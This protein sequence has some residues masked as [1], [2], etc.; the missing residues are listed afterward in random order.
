MALTVA[1]GQ[2]K[3]SPKA[4]ITLLGE[5]VTSQ[6]NNLAVDTDPQAKKLIEW[7]VKGGRG[8]IQTPGGRLF[9]CN[10][11]AFPM[12]AQSP[13]ALCSLIAA[14]EANPFSPI[15]SGRRAYR[16]HWLSLALA[17]TNILLQSKR[18]SK[19]VLMCVSFLMWIAYHMGD[20]QTMRV[21][22]SGYA[23]LIV[24]HWDLF[25]STPYF[26]N[27]PFFWTFP[28]N[29][30]SILP[31]TRNPP[32]GKLPTTKMEEHIS[33]NTLMSL[34]LA[35]FISS[36][37][38]LFLP[39]LLAMQS[40][41]PEKTGQLSTPM[42]KDLLTY[43]LY[44]GRTL[45]SLEDVALSNLETC[46]QH[47]CII[48]YY[49]CVWRNPEAGVGWLVGSMQSDIVKAGLT[50]LIDEY[51]EVLLWFTLLAGHFA[52]S[53][54]RDWWI[55]ILVSVRHAAHLDSYEEARRTMEGR[56]LWTRWLDEAARGFWN[57]TSAIIKDLKMP[58]E[59]SSTP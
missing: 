36:D 52:R 40:M 2:I 1:T 26:R 56:L 7:F 53:L 6:F 49:A 50:R 23:A 39:H 47:A 18:P 12:I 29:E 27:G 58:W 54:A 30:G 48:F 19:E 43:I 20:P 9:T 37:L 4:S 21:H 16:D 51:S 57:E 44:N 42:A 46:V 45:T 28:S 3:Q 14:L 15:R 38:M 25:C 55:D 22:F 13:A 59:E 5:A 32:E 24:R 34:H 8:D 17:N 11:L 33:R 41:I 31:E 35:G 10:R